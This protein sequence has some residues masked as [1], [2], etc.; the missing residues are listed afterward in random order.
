MRRLHETV[1]AVQ[2]KEDVALQVACGEA[3]LIASGFCFKM[4]TAT[5][6]RAASFWTGIM[7]AL[8]TLCGV[9]GLSLRNSILDTPIYA[10]DEYAYLATGKL[11][12]NVRCSGGTILVSRKS[13][14]FFTSGSS[15]R[16]S[17]LPATLG[18]R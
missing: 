15:T 10:S 8:V 16:R 6:T 5:S 18:T 1:G 11:T 9:S 17:L 3:N 2:C 12:K 13:R 14:T 4:S 7:L